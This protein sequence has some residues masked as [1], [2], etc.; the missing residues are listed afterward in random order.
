M[1]IDEI[2]LFVCNQSLGWFLEA[3]RRSIGVPR[4][5]TIDTFAEV[6]NLGAAS[7]LFNLDRAS[8]TGR[9]KDGDLVLLYSPGAGFTRTAV[10]YRWW[11]RR[12]VR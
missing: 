4:E 10:V 7:L 5:K 3:C 12:G 2:S 8:R 1:S 9:L 11:A 6:G